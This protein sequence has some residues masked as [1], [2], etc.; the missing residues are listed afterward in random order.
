MIEVARELVHAAGDH[1]NIA[2][3]NYSALLPH[4]CE[5][6]VALPNIP[7]MSIIHKGEGQWRCRSWSKRTKYGCRGRYA[8]KLKL[9]RCSSSARIRSGCRMS[10]GIFVIARGGRCT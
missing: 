8:A 9:G 3:F 1:R 2:A 10:K 5:P 6:A 7:A 4:V